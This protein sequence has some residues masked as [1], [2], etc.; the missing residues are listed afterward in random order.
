MEGRE[1]GSLTTGEDS[2]WVRVV[3]VEEQSHENHEEKSEETEEKK[4]KEDKAESKP[5]GSKSQ[6]KGVNFTQKKSADLKETRAQEKVCPAGEEM[7][8]QGGTGSERPEVELSGD[9]PGGP[10]G[11]EQH[12]YQYQTPHNVASILDSEDEDLRNETEKEDV[13]KALE[14]IVSCHNLN[15][16][17]IDVRTA[18]SQIGQVPL[19]TEKEQLAYMRKIIPADADPELYGFPFTKAEAVESE[20]H[21]EHLH[22]DQNPEIRRLENWFSQKFA[23][24]FPDRLCHPGSWGLRAFSFRQTTKL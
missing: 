23:R 8:D 17:I 21:G 16:T 22:R 18:C 14:A 13:L 1:E 20:E 9:T 15:K 2:P 3:K 7:E 4:L 5:S 10:A 11:T 12:E 19:A 6:K 24:I